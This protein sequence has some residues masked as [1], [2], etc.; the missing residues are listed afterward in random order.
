MVFALILPALP[1]LVELRLAEL[2]GPNG[3]QEIYVNPG[4]VAS[5]RAPSAADHAHFAPGARCLVYMSSGN[6]VLVSETCDEVRQR[7]Q[8]ATH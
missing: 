6:F 1:W 3:R 4:E 7:L 8:D 2:H 5:V